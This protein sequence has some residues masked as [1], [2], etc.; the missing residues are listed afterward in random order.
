VWEFG[1]LKSQ[2]EHGLCHGRRLSHC[3]PAV[4]KIMRRK[5]CGYG[6]KH[7]ADALSCRNISIRKSDLRGAELDDRIKNKDIDALCSAFA[8]INDPDDVSKLLEDLCTIREIQDM[9]Q[10]LSVARLLDNGESYNVISEK[11]G[12]SAT[13]IARVSK[14]L[15]YGSGGYRIVLDGDGSSKGADSGKDGK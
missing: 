5:H 10:R 2:G 14:A 9:A 12:A 4:T 7:I 13:T 8:T 11:T 15:N 1:Q 3:L 6:E